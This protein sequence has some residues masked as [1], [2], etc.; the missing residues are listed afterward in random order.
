MPESLRPKLGGEPPVQRTRASAAD[1]RLR[2]SSD[3][4][5]E[6][7]AGREATGGSRSQPVSNLGGPS[8]VALQISE[9]EKPRESSGIEPVLTEEEQ[10]Q[11]SRLKERDREVRAHESAHASTGA[12]L[13]GSPSFDFVTGPDGRQY[14]VGG[15]VDID[16]G[17]IAGDPEAT[18]AKAEVVIRAALAPAQPSGQDR[19]VAAGAEATKRQAQQEIAARD[20]EEAAEALKGDDEEE[21]PIANIG[22][23]EQA[24]TSGFSSVLSQASGAFS[25]LGDTLNR[26]DDQLNVNLLV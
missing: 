23:E 7:R 25:Q 10:S 1:T 24:A 5:D 9:G 20:R 22:N 21:S 14:A 12:G 3:N 17:A 4:Q 26:R 2:N 13:T 11:V 6:S 19:S 16:T 18:I 15:H 8:A